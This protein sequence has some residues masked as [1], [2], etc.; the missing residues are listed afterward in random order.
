[1]GY[2]AGIADGGEIELCPPELL[3]GFLI[4]L[5]LNNQSCGVCSA[6]PEPQY[7]SITAADCFN[8]Q[9][10]LWQY[11]C[12]GVG[13]IFQSPLIF[14]FNIDWQLWRNH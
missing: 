12:Y 10:Q 2:R 6:R 5:N 11:Q 13:L 1:V 14:D 9:P 3:P 7:K 4:K 8:V